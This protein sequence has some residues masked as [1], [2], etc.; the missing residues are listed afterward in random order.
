MNQTVVLGIVKLSLIAGSRRVLATAMDDGQKLLLKSAP[1]TSL[2]PW[3]QQGLLVTA[4]HASDRGPRLIHPGKT[5]ADPRF[6][7]SF[8]AWDPLRIPAQPAF[9]EVLLEA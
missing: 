1:S 2:H 8:R 9:E 3:V 7:C 6:N 5:V 4:N